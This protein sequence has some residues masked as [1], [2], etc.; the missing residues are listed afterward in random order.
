MDTRNYIKGLHHVT[1]T[2]NDAQE[3]FDFYT[4][5]LGLRLVKKTVNFDNNQ[6]YHFYYGTEVGTPGTIMTTF[7]YKGH[8]VREG[9]IGTGQV[10]ITA[11]SVP[12]N[13]LDFWRQRLEQNDVAFRE[14]VKFGNT[15]L[16]FDDPSGLHLEIVGNN[17]DDRAP[18]PTDEVPS[19]YG[20]QGF[21]NAN[22]LI[23]DPQPTID[24]LINEMGFEQGTTEGDTTRFV[25]QG[26]GASKYLDLQ[27]D[28]NGVRG[29]NGL[30]TVHHVALR[31]ET[32]E[33]QVRLRER[34]LELG[35]RVTDIKDRK[36]FHS[37][38]FRIPGGVLF[39]VATIPPGFTV[40]ESKEELGLDLKLPAWEEPQRAQIE[41]VLPQVQ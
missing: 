34:L 24:F 27:A 39:E 25:I 31:I 32:D 14:A 21:F 29:L 26:G 35:F 3:D 17:E 13:A 12:E 37:I 10:S 4:K 36:Y 15:V 20:I 28:P 2:V 5:L 1:A 7:P 9:V 11:F 19:E 23:A 16:Q 22:M 41:S 40:D 6:V 18:W 30:G 38:Y 33:E 8:G